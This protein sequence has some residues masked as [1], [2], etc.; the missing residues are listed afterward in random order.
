[1]N[2]LE[3]SLGYFISY[4]LGLKWV[5]L[6][7]LLW[8]RRLSWLEGWVRA[9]IFPCST[10]EVC[11]DT[12]GWRAQKVLF[13]V[14]QCLSSVAFNQDC[15]LFILYLLSH[16]LFRSAQRSCVMKQESGFGSS[17]SWSQCG[18]CLL[19]NVGLV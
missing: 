10:L 11:P 15:D 19:S 6:P 17:W 18:F 1:M 5:I 4:V 16:P 8:Q 7:C 12:D 14:T 3:R 2:K 9:L 13:Q